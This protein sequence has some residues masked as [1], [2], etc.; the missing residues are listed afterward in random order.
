MIFTGQ[1]SNCFFL[2]NFW[3]GLETFTKIDQQITS[4][5]YINVDEGFV[6]FENILDHMKEIKI[7]TVKM[8]RAN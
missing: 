7:I 8:R 5:D 3:N 6:V 1:L 2:L 4:E